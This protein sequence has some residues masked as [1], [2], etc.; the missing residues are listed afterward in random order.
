MYFTTQKADTHLAKRPE[1]I[2]EF[3]HNNANKSRPKLPETLVGAY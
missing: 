3:H 1:Q 2:H